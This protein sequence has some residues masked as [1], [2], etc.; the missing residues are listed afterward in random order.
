V[1]TCTLRTAA[2]NG[3]IW[4]Q[5]VM[6][7]GQA[8]AT[9]SRPRRNRSIPAITSGAARQMSPI[10]HPK[11]AG[12]CFPITPSSWA[13][14]FKPSGTLSPGADDELRAG[15]R[16]YNF[17]WYRV[18][19]ITNL[20]QMCIDDNGR[21]YEFGVPPPLVR[22]ELVEQMRAEAESLL[23]PQYSTACST[24]TSPSLRLYTISARPAWSSD[25]WRW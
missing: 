14:G 4:L 17:G 22:K 6:D 16:R 9:S 23:P 19:D 2:A 3:P 12:Q 11:R 13:I 10:L 1:F 5:D 20:R 21:E 15:H 25:A 18:A 8:F 24:S 7:S